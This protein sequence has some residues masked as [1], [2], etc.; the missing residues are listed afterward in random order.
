MLGFVEF[1]VT[2]EKEDNQRWS[3]TNSVWSGQ[4]CTSFDS[5]ARVRQL[6]NTI[7][8]NRPGECY[9]L[10]NSMDCNGNG[11]NDTHRF[12]KV[13][14]CRCYIWCKWIFWIVAVCWLPQGMHHGTIRG[15]HAVTVWSRINGLPYRMKMTAI[16]AQ[17]RLWLTIWIGLTKVSHLVS[18]IP[19]TPNIGSNA[20]RYVTVDP[21]PDYKQKWKEWGLWI[22]CVEPSALQVRV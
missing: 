7:T 17:V 21:S 8:L 5:S 18:S 4:L 13:Y 14:H 19:V 10:V 20:N 12:S 15:G 3:G 9:V 2:W 6:R 22:T 16:M 11:A 1:G